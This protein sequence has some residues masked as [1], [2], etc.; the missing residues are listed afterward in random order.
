MSETDLPE[1]EARQAERAATEGVPVAKSRRQR[2]SLGG[3]IVWFGVSYGGA[4]LGYL[5]VNAFAARLL[6]DSFGYFVIAITVSTLFGQLGLMGVHR[7]GLREAARMTPGDTAVLSELRRGVRAVLLIM[8]PATAIGTGAATFAVLDTPDGGVRWSVAVG[9]GVLVYLGGQQKLWANFLRGLGHVRFASLL[10]GRSGGAIAS[11]GQGVL[12]G[13]VLLL[14]PEWGLPGAL[15]AM[16]LGLALPVLVAWRTV[17]RIWRH[18]DGSGPI[19][20]DML[21]V[22]RRY[23]RFASNLLGGYLNSTVEIWLAALVLTGA[24]LSQFSAAQRLSVLLAVPL[25]SLGV[26]FSPVVSRLVGQDDQR[27]ERLLRT[28]A[29]MAAS[30]TAVVWIPMLVVPGRLLGLIFGEEFSQGAP[31]LVLL[32][33]GSF[34]N[35]LSGMCGTALTM[36]RHESVVAT[37]QW[38]AVVLRVALGAVAALAFGA[39]GLGASAA[40]VTIGLYATLWIATRRRLG[41]WTHPTLRPSL[42]LMR[43]TKS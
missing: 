37:V 1:R 14:R 24:G 36:S 20:Q 33:V 4:I 35:V 5:A 23:W 6:N 22:V 40:V 41:M 31:I 25:I 15:G 8:L 21:A 7:G 19:L 9:M 16:A 18:A 43:Q 17:H 2:L 29:T 32:T 39:I 42:R 3:A 34:A 30:I 10:E 13:M 26:V 38:V 11:A 28:G 12:V 27:L